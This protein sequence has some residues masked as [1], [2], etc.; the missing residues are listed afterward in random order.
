M[1]KVLWFLIAFSF[2]TSLN[3]QCWKA[4]SAGMDHT[5]AIKPDG[6]LWAWGFNGSGQLGTGNTDEKNLPT[7]VGTATNWQTV[8]AGGN[9]SFAIKTDGTLWGW[10]DN[11]W[12]QVGVGNY[13]TKIYTPTKIGTS[14]NW[15][16][17]S[18]GR[19]FTLGIQTDGTLWAWGENLF[20]QLGT[21]QAP[22]PVKVGFE[23]NWLSVDAGNAH[24]IA[25]KT[26]GTLWGWGLNSY[27]QL[28]N[29]TTIEKST[30]QRIG[31]DTNWLGIAAGNDFSMALKTNGT[32]WTWGS[33]FLGQLGDGTYIDKKTPTQ[34]GTSSWKIISA[35]NV[36][37]LAV[38]AD[39]SLSSW[40]W[41]LGEVGFGVGNSNNTPTQL[42]V[43]SNWQSITSGDNHTFAFKTDGTLWGWG[44]GIWGQ[45]GDGTWNSYIE[46]KSLST[47]APTGEAT[48]IFCNSATVANLKA[49]GTGVKWY[50]S[51]F[52]GVALATNTILINGNHYYASQIS[53]SCESVSRLDVT[54]SINTTP[55]PP[56]T[57][58]AS[59]TF[60]GSS[61]IVNLMAT[62]ANLKWYTSATSTTAL[63]TTTALVNGNRYYASQTVNGCES[64]T[65][66]EVIV[67]V[68]NT[69][70][71]TGSATQVFCV[72]S[73]ISN[74]A[75]TG[76]NIKWYDVAT[77]GSALPS[78]TLLIN[79]SAYYASQ[80]INS[81]ESSGR[82]KV[83]VSVN[84][85]PTPAGQS[86]QFF[87]NSA[88]ISNLIATG[89][90][91]KWYNLAVGGTHL[92]SSTQLTD[93]SIYY[94]TQTSNSCES[95]VRLSVVVTINTTPT[96]PPIGSALQTVCIGSPVASLS[97]SGTGIKWYLTS[98]GGVPLSASAIA[99]NGTHYFASQTFNG[100]ES[101]SR[102][103]VTVTVNTTR[104]SLP[105]TS[106]VSQKWQSVTTGE[107]HNLGITNDGTLWAWGNNIFGQLGDGTNNNISLPKLIN[108]DT[109]WQSVF[110]GKS[111]TLA[112]KSDGTLW[113]WGLNDNGQLGDGTTIN[114]NTPV[115]IGSDSDW[116]EVSCGNLHTMAIKKDGTL[117][118][119][120][121]NFY[122]QLGDQTNTDRKIPTQLSKNIYWKKVSAGWF[123]TIAINEDGTL[124]AWGENFWGRLGD[125]TTDNKNTPTKIS[126]ITTWKLIAAGRYHS[127][128]LRSDSDQCYTWGYLDGPSPSVKRL[129]DRG[130]Y[131]NGNN[132][133][134]A[135][136]GAGTSFALN[137]NNV[138]WAW[139][140]NNVGQLGNVLPTSGVQFPTK[141]WDKDNLTLL[142]SW[143]DHS[144]AVQNDTILVYFGGLVDVAPTP[145][146]IF[147]TPK[148]QA[149]CGAATISDFQ[150]QGPN[151]KWYDAA[152]GGA[153]L[154]PNTPLINLKNYFVTQTVNSCESLERLS[155][156]AIINETPSLPPEGSAIQSVCIEG[157]IADLKSSG[158]NIKWYDTPSGGTLLSSTTSLINGNHYYASQTIQSCES[159]ARL[160]VLVT[161]NA[162]TTLAPLGESFQVLCEGSTVSNLVATGSQIQWYATP[163]GGTA[164]ASS[165]LLENNT[166]YFASQTVNSCES[167]TRLD[168]TVSTNETT[169]PL[170]SSPQNFQSISSNSHHN[171]AIK[172]DGTLWAWG[173]NLYGELGNNGLLDLNVPIQ[174]GAET[175]WKS[176]SA[177]N[178]HSVA[179]KTDGT[180]WSW[181]SNSDEALGIGGFSVNVPVQV[182]TEANWEIVSAGKDHNLAIK[183]DGTLWAWGTNKSGQLGDGTNFTRETPVQIGSSSDWKSIAAGDSHSYSIKEDGTLWAWG[184]NNNGQLGDGSNIN[185]NIPT[186]IGI[187]SNWKSIVSGRN[188][189]LA[190]KADGTLW[191]WG[192]S[193]SLLPT[194]VGGV[195]SQWK[196]ID[197]GTSHYLAIK[198]DGSLWAWGGYYYNQ[199]ES[200]YTYLNTITQIGSDQ[201]WQLVSG[202]RD[203]SIATKVDGSLWAWGWN[204]L[205]QLGDGTTTAKTTPT[206]V[207]LP[208]SQTFCGSASVADLAITGMEI[209]WYAT[210]SG[211]IPLA[212]T[213][214]LVNGNHYYASQTVNS[215]ES[216]S[217]LNVVVTVNSNL[218]PSGNTTQY[219]CVGN[220]VANL[221][222]SGTNIKWYSTS[223][224]GVPLSP[225]TELV[226]G[227]RYYATQ[228][229]S[230]CESERLEVIATVTSTVPPTGNSTQ[231]FCKTSTISNLIASGTSIKWYTTLTGGTPL[232]P[233]NLLTNGSHYYASQIL[234][235]CE[236]PSRLD[237]EVE[238]IETSAPTGG[239]SQSFCDGAIVNSLN[240][241]G[242]N[243]KWYATATGGI[244]LSV[245]TRLVNGSHYYASQTT[246]SCES[247]AR[248][249][250]TA[251]VNTTAPPSGTSVQTFCS[252]ATV[253]DLIASGSN[254]KWYA[255]AFGGAPMEITTQLV[256]GNHYYASQTLNSCESLNRLDAIVL[257]SGAPTGSS[258]QTFC[259]SATIANLVVSGT[260]IKWYSSLTDG[261]P[262]AITTALVNGSHYYASQTV[263]SCESTTRLEVTAFI[264]LTDKPTGAS[265]QTFCQGATV[266]ALS[267]A[268][269]NIKWYSNLTGGLQLSLNALL[270][271]NAQYF[272][273]QTLSGCESTT[274][275][276]VS[277]K[278][279]PVPLPPTGPSIQSFENGKTISDLAATGTGV[280][281]Y[282]S[283][284]E[285][286]K[287]TNPLSPTYQLINGVTYFAT[288]TINDCESE[289]SLA[290]TV[291]IIT[292][293][294]LTNSQ[295]KFYPNPVKDF[296]II[297]VDFQI[298]SV[299]VINPLGQ[300]VLSKQINDTHVKLD[301]SELESSIYLI[302]LNTKNKVSSFRVMKH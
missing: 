238:I 2:S 219:F 30:P 247:N 94:A 141:A 128:A 157:S 100:C 106:L 111:H 52:G 31:S 275:L 292:G 240:A 263:N 227:N 21:T 119:W 220:T 259:S 205:G 170:L 174:I 177:G 74:L 32:L 206:K 214:L 178:F 38:K 169:L 207:T 258:V 225:N 244:P 183:T 245:T 272:A 196:T 134:A 4:V 13:G 166:H 36:N 209:K 80:T 163:T 279:N 221:E 175:N 280:K 301:M 222:A 197:A 285:A 15:K 11:Y 24:T 208:A 204:E 293:I 130:G 121:N 65:R 125:G 49:N 160:D 212:P 189:G 289:G 165:T 176:V 152:I 102:L 235:S 41:I 129:I 193:S 297:A 232:L 269:T 50:S 138:L 118:G 211:G 191:T 110:A 57:G 236:S 158:S 89:T 10:G 231:K 108:S 229:S 33:N 114:R 262:L 172:D 234:N 40:G 164:I 39:G 239:V 241:T 96:N 47:L 91:I 72:A 54:V 16:L 216:F 286:L 213:E 223:I 81:C 42:G 29:G 283:D 243:I 145:T 179:I 48:Q 137:K 120:G 242:S 97:V 124:W 146:L 79:G 88:T 90:N 251:T 162:T 131:I 266:A 295:F 101:S 194:Q 75:I 56:P 19:D 12:G 113:A 1:K 144:L 268:G 20:G 78:S 302:Y 28:G 155:I 135:A 34:I 86:T 136:V 53:N 126:I 201:D 132:W 70:I 17:I 254:I 83:T 77:G 8:S 249:N 26:D 246:N 185:K 60:C 181:G 276:I 168:V 122:G 267:A 250:V 228:T 115:Q 264:S 14:T 203:H 161:L 147:Y 248:L 150:V 44:D 277:V 73:T 140:K 27:G 61:T 291:S 25:I 192:N 270:V 6:T 287:K 67:I 281:W 273:T 59:Q 215:C 109:N 159:S 173:S 148:V 200:N 198:S 82:F 95:P 149:F 43:E 93:G 156:T 202:G 37:S 66:L 218:A 199:L 7:Q 71:P 233:D 69:S 62:G 224:G 255:S 105:T 210:A 112:I 3:A 85:T 290:V 117:W 139:G 187:D 299:L 151:L 265:F 104:S 45:I 154:S 300:K 257:I 253:E 256:S 195:N 46:P 260:E 64:T 18:A 23:N 116:S 143:G 188:F 51:A 153:P 261:T 296:L 98:T 171:L 22:L 294:E 127:L 186:T 226:D 167:Q 133:K 298:E 9:H 190:V 58:S 284:N 278:V 237:V 252:N 76:T 274:R 63:S 180:L 182:G 103:D 92:A 68:N 288:Q 142:S 271:N 84:I 107:R 87:C 123:H 230:L 184:N 55:T 217:R 5:I 35:G 99:S 282:S